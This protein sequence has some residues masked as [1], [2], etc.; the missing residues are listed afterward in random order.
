MDAP[1]LR[2]RV[3]LVALLLSSALVVSAAT[4]ARSGRDEQTLTVSFLDVGQGD[5]VLV[6]S[7]TGTQVLI[8]G[9]AGPQILPALAWVLPRFDRTLDLVVATHPDTDHVGGLVDVLHSYRV[10]AV[11]TT[12]NESDAPAARAF[13]EAVAAEASV[14]FVARTGQVYDLG[15]GAQLSVLYPAYNPAALESNVASIIL[16][17][18]YGGTSFLLT[19]DAPIRIEDYLVSQYGS[20][21]MSTVLKAGHHGSKTSSGELFVAT[22]APAL[23]I[24]SAGADNRYGHPHQVV[25]DIFTEHGVP[26]RYTSTEGTITLTSDGTRVW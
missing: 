8:D 24:I 22:V 10:S 15:G 26:L 7:P 11:L 25:V 21:L 17:V 23:G 13:V 18:T 9:G 2:I 12:E 3:V 6:E 1:L 5:A 16:R 14:R 20:S 19:G 4:V